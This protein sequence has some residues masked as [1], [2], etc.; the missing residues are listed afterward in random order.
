MVQRALSP[1]RPRVAAATVAALS[2][3]GGAPPCMTGACHAPF[4][5]L[6]PPRQR[7]AASLR[8]PPTFRL[9]WARAC[10]SRAPPSTARG[11][12]SRHPPLSLPLCVVYDWAACSTARYGPSTTAGVARVGW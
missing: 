11:S 2:V 8:V 7:P 9:F 12:V 3:G 6:A 5:V 4:A 1:P 10:P